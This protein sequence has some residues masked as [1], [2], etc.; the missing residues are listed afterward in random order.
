MAFV[1]IPSGLIDVGDAIKKELFDLIKSN[2]DDHETRISALATGQAKIDVFDF[3]IRLGSIATSYTGMV[4]YRA[5][6]AFTLSAV[7]L[8]IYEAGALTGTLECDV[9][10]NTSQDNVGMSSI[11][12]TRPSIALASAS[13]YDE[14]TN[15]V[16][17]N[18]K[19]NIAVGDILRFDI[20]SLPTNGTIGKFMFNLY[21]V[22]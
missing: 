6:Q 22:A 15:Q 11:F 20:T 9:K 13:D 21:G 14:S 12:T 19:I 5:R 16:F 2:L 4:Y 1:T 8:K 7:V 10:K 18:T 17:D 3:D